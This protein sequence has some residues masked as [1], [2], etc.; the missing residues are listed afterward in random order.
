MSFRHILLALVATQTTSAASAQ[1]VKPP[2]VKIAAGSLGGADHNG[3]TSFLGIPYAAPPVGVLRWKPTAEPLPWTGVRQA[4]RY[5]AA[6]P[7]PAD[8]EPGAWLKV[9]PQSEDCLFLNVWRPSKPGRYPVMVFIHGG[10]FNYGSA[11]VPLYDGSAL[12][13]RGVVVVSM[14]YRLG[15]LGFF[16]HPAL[17]K[18]AGTGPTGNFGVMDQI[19]ALKWV[20]R[21]I[22]G[23]GGDEKNV[24][25]FGESAGAGS[26]QALMGSSAANGL[27]HK[28]ISQSGGGG[29][30]L[31]QM[32]GGTASVEARG[33]ALLAA[34]GLP[35]ATMA[36]LRALP[37]SLILKAK[38]FPF[39]DGTIVTASPGQI[40]SQGNAMKIPLL[41]GANSNESSLMINNPAETRKILGDAYDA[42]ATKYA[43][44][45]SGTPGKAYDI[46]LA[47][48]AL[49][50]LPSFSIASMHAAARNPAYAYYFTQVPESEREKW[51]GAPHGGELEYVFGT[52]AAGETW[53]ASDVA[54]S[55]AMG[56][57]WV[58]FARAGDP[59]VPGIPRWTPVADNPVSFLTIG[60]PMKAERL[61]KH[62]EMV[63]QASLATSRTMW[64]KTEAVEK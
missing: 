24:T 43:A 41:I 55:K 39:I 53:D 29:G 27:F 21:N 58:R 42:F 19:A 61:T 45:H 47:E 40:F 28:A 57:A 62:R 52:M 20:Q 38:G 54:V 18:E 31:M 15:L 3:A 8:R 6:C 63:R 30:V 59:N 22:G 17:S 23:F 37:V 50:I 7:Q 4:S 36:Q 12:A 44:T 10:G 64:A 25:L 11:G 16:A 1:S 13:K 32:R 46:W 60:S 26:V 33:D 56:D 48:D 5:G 35:N 49:S 51:A 2:I 14:N 9:G 34:A